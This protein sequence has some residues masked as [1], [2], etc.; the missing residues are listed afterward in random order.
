MKIRLCIY[1]IYYTMQKPW[2]IR[3][4]YNVLYS[5]LKIIIYFYISKI[6]DLSLLF[7][8]S[9][10]HVNALKKKRYLYKEKD[11]I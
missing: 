11:Y 5:I 9:S 6:L 1:V 4:I 3:Y 2:Y 10:L 7:Y 8:R